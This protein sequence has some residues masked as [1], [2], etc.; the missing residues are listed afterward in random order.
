MADL[1]TRYM[2]LKLKN[3]IIVGASNLVLKTA[4]LK[5]A[6]QAGAS[7]IVYK[8]LFEE[9][10]QLERAQFSDELDSF[11][12]RNAE[13]LKLFPS[14][15][16]AGPEA[17]LADLREARKQV[18]IPLI[19]SLNAVYKESWVEYAKLLEETGVDALELNFY[20]VPH[21]AGKDATGIEAGQL[22]ILEEILQKVKIPVSVKLSSSYTN[23]LHVVS[24][25][26]KTGVA[27]FVLFNRVF[28]PDINIETEQHSAPWNLSNSEDNRQSIRFA[29]LLYKQIKADICASSGIHTGEDVVKLIL[30]GSTAVQVVSAL[31]RSK[32]EVITK[33]L[34]DVNTWMDMK[35]Y[36]NLDAFRGKLSRVNT[37]DPFVY[38]RAQY[39]DL[40]LKSEE[41]MQNNTPV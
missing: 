30:A 13:M 37:T 2:G 35:K 12:E 17:Y 15:E 18:S 32:I 22:D 33:M 27:G 34:E 19:G 29:G 6:E 4:Y 1:S 14:M 5:K 38:K 20:A 26:D 39:V 8:S 40:L 36:A 24:Q 9:Q 16:H 21:D 7:A 31:Y 41:I 23:P 28:Q 10:I 3:P 25:M 11:N